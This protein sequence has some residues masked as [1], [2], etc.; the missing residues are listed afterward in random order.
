MQSI[1]DES[2][3]VFELGRTGAWKEEIFAS[4]LERVFFCK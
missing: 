2:K 1:F 4:L 3:I